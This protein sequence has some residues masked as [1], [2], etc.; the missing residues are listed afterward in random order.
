MFHCISL[1][2]IPHNAL[3]IYLI[4]YALLFLSVATES[5][6]RRYFPNNRQAGVFIF[7]DA[8]QRG[9]KTRAAANLITFDREGEASL[10]Y[11]NLTY[12]KMRETVAVYIVC[13][14]PMRRDELSPSRS[15]IGWYNGGSLRIG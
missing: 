8:Q 6:G 11:G 5:N 4:F 1:G 13:A 14:P 15:E 3:Q 12:R 9:Q 7:R 2:K 10:F